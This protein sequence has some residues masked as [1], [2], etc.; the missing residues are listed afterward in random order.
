[1][2]Y[3]ALYLKHVFH[4]NNEFRLKTPKTKFFK[5]APSFL[6][7][8]FNISNL[9]KSADIFLLLCDRISNH[10]LFNINRC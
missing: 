6:L 1:M 8:K 4:F 7:Q 10:R 5:G 3:G 2:H 9:E